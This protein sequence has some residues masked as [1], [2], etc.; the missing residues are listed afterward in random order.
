ML[1][2]GILGC[3]GKMGKT[4]SEEALKRGY[5]VAAG[6][7]HTQIIPKNSLFPIFYT[8]ESV[9]EKSSILIDFSHADVALLH[10]E[11]AQ[12]FGIPLLIGT[13]GHKKSFV[14]LFS[15]NPPS[16]PILYAP[17]TSVTL[18]LF[19]KILKQFYGL[20]EGEVDVTILEK[21][22]RHKKD[23]PSGTALFLKETLLDIYPEASIPTVSVRGGEI[24]GEH[25]VSFYKK[26]ET[27][28]FLHQ[29]LS[30]NIFAK[31]ALNMAKWLQQQAPGFYTP[32]DYIDVLE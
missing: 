29:A 5:S 32:S 2:I 8:P 25:H 3:L 13:T 28:T 15:E 1:K 31:G 20:L 16:V 18:H 9:F 23:V 14:S 24:F 12:Q 26:E 7:T 19:A 4:L 21:H 30:R 6:S 17:N 11:L 10:I 22:H 27:I